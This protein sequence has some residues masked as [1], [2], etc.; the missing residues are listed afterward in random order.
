MKKCWMI[1]TFW[2]MRDFTINKAHT[3]LNQRPSSSCCFDL[4]GHKRKTGF[5]A[6]CFVGPCCGAT[7]V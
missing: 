5:I 3:S 1:G 4:F 7:G 2:L 6:Q